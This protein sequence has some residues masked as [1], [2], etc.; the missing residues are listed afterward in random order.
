LTCSDSGVYS[1]PSHLNRR[2]RYLG[3]FGTWRWERRLRAGG[4]RSSPF[5]G[6]L[7]YPSGPT[8]GVCHRSWL[9][10]DRQRREI[11]VRQVPGSADQGY[12]AVTERREALPCASD[13]RRSGNQAA[14]VTKVRLSAFRLPLFSRGRFT[15][16]TIHAKGFAGGDDAWPEESAQRKCARPNTRRVIRGLDPP[17]E[18]KPFGEA[19]ARVSIF[20][21]KTLSKRDGLPGHARQ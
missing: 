8:L 14:A 1:H 17:A 11:A 3:R 20:L 21:H 6:V 4:K 2:E 9:D 12:Y 15:E 5:A 18:P 7:G 10:G 16:P 13:S 19:K